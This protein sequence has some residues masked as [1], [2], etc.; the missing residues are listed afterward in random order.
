M[1]EKESQLT[2]Y[3]IFDSVK[4]PQWYYEYPPYQLRLTQAVEEY[5]SNRTQL[6][7]VDDMVG[8]YTLQFS[9]EK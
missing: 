2:Y 5:L 4:A 7:L 3:I 9:N 6:F 8:L 1:N